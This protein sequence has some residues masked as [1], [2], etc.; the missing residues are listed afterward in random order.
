MAP[1]D[2]KFRTHVA[3]AFAPLNKTAAANSFPAVGSLSAA[4]IKYIPKANVQLPHDIEVTP[5]IAAMFITAAVEMWQRSVHSFLISASLTEVSP[6]WA[7]VCGY[8]SS[9][10]AVRAAAHLLGHFQLFR[11][12]RLVRLST[13][14]GKSVCTFDSKNA[15][16]REHKF[17]WRV[18]KADPHFAADD[19][20]T[21]NDGAP[22][23]SDVGH[24]DK[25]SYIDHLT[26]YPM[27]RPLN[28]DNLGSRID[29][30]TKIELKA[31]PLPQISKCPD[32]ESTQLIAYYR[33]VTFRRLVDEILGGGNRFWKVQRV[34]SWATQ[35][36][37][38][39]LVTKP[40]DLSTVGNT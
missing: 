11:N 8:Y 23:D 40:L 17:Y 35:F 29:Y 33:L 15:K 21:I 3:A 19:F 24:R 36:L 4:L 26:I 27:F 22:A 20:F 25:A 32:V 6:I 38:F 13:T 34:P 39:Q 9:H 31:P 1:I 18:V 28:A 2:P 30:I 7:A 10:Y 14:N 16:D 5:K 12:K 37:N